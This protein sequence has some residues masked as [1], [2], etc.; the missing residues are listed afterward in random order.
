[1]RPE[2]FLFSFLLFASKVG[3][4]QEEEKRGRQLFGERGV[5]GGHFLLHPN[6]RRQRLRLGHLRRD[7]VSAGAETRHSEATS[8]L[9]FGAATVNEVTSSPQP[10]LVDDW[11]P[12]R[13][14][15]H[16][17]Y[18]LGGSWDL[19]NVSKK[20]DFYFYFFLVALKYSQEAFA[21]LV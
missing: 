8:H 10:N 9:L 17:H 1:M 15:E 19:L 16:R 18:I 6:D 7:G 5:T 2:V 3:H 14:R 21:L 11:R 4:L 13:G 12:L 20:T